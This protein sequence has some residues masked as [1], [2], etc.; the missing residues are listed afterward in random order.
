MICRPRHARLACYSIYCLRIEQ[1]HH[2]IQAQSQA[3]DFPMECQ[4]VLFA[5]VTELMLDV[6]LGY[7]CNITQKARTRGEETSKINDR[8]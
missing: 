4:H 6:R 1:G 7:G 2:D 8:H 3:L 5:T